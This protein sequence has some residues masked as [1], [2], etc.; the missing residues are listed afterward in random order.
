MNK[1]TGCVFKLNAPDDC[2]AI[3][4]S[5]LYSGKCP[6]KKTFDQEREELYKCYQKLSDIYCDFDDY[7]DAI[8]LA[9]KTK[10]FNRFKDRG[11]RK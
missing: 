7:L 4:G 11:Y 8:N 1:C 9:L 3:N 2:F 10:F 5:N 6:F